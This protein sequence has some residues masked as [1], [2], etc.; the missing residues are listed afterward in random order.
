MAT[1]RKK[2]ELNKFLEE[3][4]GTELNDIKEKLDTNEK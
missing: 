4:N 1:I 2:S 3:Y